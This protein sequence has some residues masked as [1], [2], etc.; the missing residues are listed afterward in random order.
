MCAHICPWW[1]GYFI[2]NPLRRWL[3]NPEKILGPYVS[4]GMTAMDVGCGMGIFSIAMARMVGDEGHVISVDI[5]QR[6]LD[7]LQRR[8]AKA[9]LAQRIQV[10]CAEPN[11]L[12]VNATVD[13]ALAFAM[14]HE[15]PDAR[16]LLQ[17]I[18]ECLKPGGHLLVTEPQGHVPLRRFNQMLDI[19]EELGLKRRQQP[20]VRYCHA[21]LLQRT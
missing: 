9:G 6:M 11:R 18:H 7:A 4:Q 3:H 15:S 5:Q 19:A 8:A 17:Q 13:F 12:G 20:F 1:G 16:N 10:H 2:D 21:A 14:V